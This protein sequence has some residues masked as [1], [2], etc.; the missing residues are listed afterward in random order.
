[1]TVC[2][3]LV[4]YLSK[5]YL[6]PTYSL[7]FGLGGF[8][9]WSLTYEEPAVLIP[10]TTRV[11]DD[12][13]LNALVSMAEDQSVLVFERMTPQLSMIQSN[14]IIVGKSTIDRARNE[15]PYGFLRRVLTTYTDGAGQFF[16]ETVQAALDEAIARGELTYTAT[17]QFD[18]VYLEETITA[19]CFAAED[20]AVRGCEL[21][22]TS[23]RISGHDRSRDL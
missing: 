21:R 20:I 9:H 16:V 19:L 6:L 5:T 18:N 13:T 10:E 17:L 11:L 14:D 4:D 8:H 22:A 1:M 23:G 2:Q 7:V 15:A 12:E 3:Y